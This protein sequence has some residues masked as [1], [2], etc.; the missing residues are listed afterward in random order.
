M[1]K[2][3]DYCYDP[4]EKHPHSITVNGDLNP[5]SFLT[6]YLHEVAHLRTQ[7][8]H[9]SRVKAH[10]EEWKEEYRK[11]L[12]PLVNEDVFPSALLDAI[13]NYIANPKASSCADIDLLKALSEYDEK[14][15]NLIFLSEVKVGMIFKFNGYAY[16]K[17]S[18]LR[19]RAL[20][21]EVKSGRQFYI[22]EGAQVEISQLTLF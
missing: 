18:T 10:G 15:D 2:L 22:S 1:T 4:R 20:C 19:T 6:T 13:K 9:G 5:F 14:R 3:G 8:L 12:A 17:E 11:L 16:R 21:K 7:V